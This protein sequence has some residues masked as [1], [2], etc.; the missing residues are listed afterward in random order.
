MLLLVSS[1]IGLPDPYG[2]EGAGWKV[3]GGVPG[4]YEKDE[5]AGAGCGVKGLRFFLIQRYFL[6]NSSSYAKIFPSGDRRG[7]FTTQNP[8]CGTPLVICFVL[9]GGSGYPDCR[10]K[11]PPF[12]AGHAE[13]LPVAHD[14]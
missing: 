13:R 9:D 12:H 5:D 6:N 4:V 1:V 3:L 8:A 11:L 2:G 7:G 10:V 14:L